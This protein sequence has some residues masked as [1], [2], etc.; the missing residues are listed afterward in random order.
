MD[1]E[2]GRRFNRLVA[3]LDPL[4]EHLVRT[5]PLALVGE[6]RLSCRLKREGRGEI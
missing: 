6:R 1:V 5:V 2:S 4:R 3:W